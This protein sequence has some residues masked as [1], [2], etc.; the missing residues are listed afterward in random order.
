MLRYANEAKPLSSEERIRP[1]RE[2]VLE[3][4]KEEK[5]TSS[6]V[7]ESPLG[8][9]QNIEASTMNQQMIIPRPEMQVEP[10]MPV[11]NLI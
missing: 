1:R 4:I 10:Q 6:P 2:E 3:E 7:P 5:Q 11:E 8:H 9:Q